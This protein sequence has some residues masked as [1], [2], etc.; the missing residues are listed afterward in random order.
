MIFKSNGPQQTLYSLM[1][2]GQLSMAH[3][4]TNHNQPL[5]LD[6]LDYSIGNLI[7]I[8]VGCSDDLAAAPGSRSFQVADE[9]GHSKAAMSAAGDA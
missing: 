8:F 1:K 3:F 6:S 4:L 2:L 7:P 5:F 9:S